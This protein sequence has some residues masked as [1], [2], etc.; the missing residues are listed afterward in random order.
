MT[1]RYDEIME[2]IEVTDE[3]RDRI[4]RHVQAADLQP[5][6]VHPL[7]RK[8]Y[9]KQLLAAAA[10]LAILL[11]G[12][13]TLPKLLQPNTPNTME[14]NGI[15]AFPSVAALEEAVGFSLPQNLPFAPDAVS[16]TAYWG[17]LA[18]IRYES[19]GQ[20]VCFRKSPGAEDNSGDY[21]NYPA[22]TEC[23]VNGMQI[24]LKGAEDSFT[25]ATWTDGE[26]SYS[27]SLSNG[28]SAAAWENL[29]A[30]ML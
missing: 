9:F 6:P 4:L 11:V 7:R 3:M 23:T 5:E 12:G 18:E 8:P 21:N 13:L 27:L 16:C 10:C 1:R 20:A 22:Q 24:T 25:L 30:A 17:S 29:I 14:S 2:H 28:L 26:F 15:V 19:G